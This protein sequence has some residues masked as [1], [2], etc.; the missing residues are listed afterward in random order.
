ME[1]T[2]QFQYNW[3]VKLSFLVTSPLSSFLLHT[4]F[5][6]YA[7]YFWKGHFREASSC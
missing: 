1:V 7:V 3:R 4:A 5:H 2:S 6:S